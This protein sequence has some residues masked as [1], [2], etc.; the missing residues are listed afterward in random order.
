MVSL[1]DELKHNVKDK[2]PA[3]SFWGY[4]FGSLNMYLAYLL[5]SKDVFRYYVLFLLFIIFVFF[6]YIFSAITSLYVDFTSDEVKPRDVFYLYGLTE[7]FTLLLIPV[8]YFSI[9]FNFNFQILEFAVFFSI[10]VMRIVFVKNRYKLGVLNS[11][12]SV[13]FPHI[14]LFIILASFVMV[15]F[16]LYMF[17]YML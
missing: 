17:K 4:A 5:V 11:I 14:M 6:N 2:Y 1:I 3:I 16:V 13:F 10:W 12:V 9:Y 15:G 8:A 7:Y